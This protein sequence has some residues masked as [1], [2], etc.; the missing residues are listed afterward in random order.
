M[1]LNL[2]NGW[3]GSCRLPL[4]RGSAASATHQTFTD[5]IHVLTHFACPSGWV[6]WPN[7]FTMFR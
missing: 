4:E 3:A 7:A 5:P 2:V 1:W 6:L